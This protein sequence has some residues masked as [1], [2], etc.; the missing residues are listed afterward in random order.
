MRMYYKGLGL[1]EISSTLSVSQK[2]S[3]NYIGSSIKKLRLDKGVDGYKLLRFYEAWL[4][5]DG[6]DESD[7]ILCNY[8]LFYLR[9]MV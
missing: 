5:G 6:I 9:S 2:T 1:R 8:R 7:N 4:Q 3:L